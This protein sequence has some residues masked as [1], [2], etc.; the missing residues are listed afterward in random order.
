MTGKE[1]LFT[2]KSEFETQLISVADWWV[3]H[4][5]DNKNGG[6]FGEISR[7]GEPNV[8][9]EKAI[10]L[11]SRILW[12]FSELANVNPAEQYLNMAHRAY[13]YM[14]K[15]FEDVEHG[16]V[17]W[18]L[19]CNGHPVDTKKQ[20][21]AQAFTI[22][23]YSAYYRLTGN[24][25]AIETAISIQALLEDKARD[26]EYNGYLDAFDQQWQS[27]DDMRLSEDDEN[28]PKKM[29]THLHVL[30]A[31][32]GIH[33]A[34][35]SETTRR[36]LT[37]IIQCYCRQ[38]VSQENYHL[39]V[40]VEKD[41]TDKSACYSLGHDIESSWL[42]WEALLVLDDKALINEFKPLVNGINAVCLQDGVGPSGEF[43]DE[44]HFTEGYN[45]DRVWWIQAEALVGFLTAF[46]L[47]RNNNF[48]EAFK[49]VWEF[50]KI[51]QIDSDHGEWFW[52]SKL[53]SGYLSTYKAGAWKG[54]YHNGRALLEVIKLIDSLML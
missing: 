54:P 6:F 41:W 17:F 45:V 4:A 25:Q 23:A 31:Y 43:R 28:F 20:V 2:L 10:V 18:H 50:I 35:P 52:Y 53:D 44:F 13:E 47:T 24:Q 33:L 21:Y 22:Y 16:G 15:H 32:T 37:N 36:A 26:H 11:N 29:N 19:D 8:E 30:E 5:I 1:D 46:Q 9:A 39:R 38:F 3:Q 12:F 7:T 27:M 34:A 51:N 14:V 40:Y 48:L 49:R 42:I